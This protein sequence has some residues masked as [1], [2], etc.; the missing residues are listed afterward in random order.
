MTPGQNS[1]ITQKEKDGLTHYEDHAA[2][3]YGKISASI[4]SLVTYFLTSEF[5]FLATTIAMLAIMLA[6]VGNIK[7]HRNLIENGKGDVR[8][9]E[10]QYRYLSTAFMLIT[11]IW[12]FYCFILSD[13]SF[14]HLLCISTVLGNVL[15]LLSRNF[16]DDRTLTLQ[17]CAVGI[18]LIMGV[19]SYGD[20]RAMIL[21]GFFMPLFSSVHDISARLR[22]LFRNVEAQS[23]EKEAFG[24]QLNEAL[25]SMSHGLIMFDEEMRLR[26]INQTAR[27][28]LVISDDINCF[29]KRLS[30]ISRAIELQKPYV[31]R[32]QVLEEALRR[33]L[34][35]RA[36][37]K[38]F[39]MSEKQHIELSIKL[40]NRGGCVL[41]I[42]DV[43]QRI[44]YQD[45]INQLARFDDLTGLCNRNYFYQQ[46]ENMAA[47]LPGGQNAGIIFFDLD[48][49][50]RINDMLG[51]EAGDFILANVAER[52]RD[53]L[54]K[55]AI[56][57]RHGGD[58]FV[59]YVEGKYCPEGFEALAQQ[60]ISEL[61]RP[62]DYNKQNLRFGASI[63]V[64]VYPD[65]AITIDRLLKLA[66]LALYE[67]KKAGKNCYTFFSP[68]MEDTLQERL[69]MENDLTDA[70]RSNSLELH[71]QPIVSMATQKP[72][73]FEAL[74][75]WN[76]NNTDNVSPA[77]FIPL[78]EDLGLIREIGEWTLKE[79]CRQCTTWHPETSVAV[80]VSAVQF[81]VGSITEAVQAALIE[82]GLD[83]HRL[84]IEIT[85]SAVLNDMT[86]AVLVLERLSEIGVRISLDDFGTGYSSL[87]YL[88]KLPLD[89]L[90]I[91]KSFID[92]LVN[93]ERSKTLLKGITAM[94]RALDLRLVVEGIE[95][96]HQFDL[97]KD[98]YNVD[99][100]QGYF[101]SK[102]LPA[103]AA[104]QFAESYYSTDGD[105]LDSGTETNQMNDPR[106]A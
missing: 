88:H 54:P 57:G 37:N 24:I 46:S 97:L 41:V 86:H 27:Q 56:I 10:Y 17:L 100:M 4:A 65:D 77:I 26:V 59:I 9:W 16:L 105:A 62:L 106:V 33:R 40:R 43:S 60:L 50:K 42:E 12:S 64:A 22:S 29:G 18:P 84:E 35:N 2:F 52:M 70:V 73:V 98:H 76:R 34:Q 81:Q 20:F 5:T 94:G 49:F 58:E 47:S 95:N 36:H 3:F 25:E 75:R 104:K 1:T 28:I 21:C 92:D 38:I 79:A 15:N 8:V 45:R 51:H 61:T 71:F 80:N 13:N 32:V 102:A 82:T 53:F 68:E 87:S 63:G 55:Q 83:P 72:A 11:G 23:E 74:T 99:F 103:P 93:S 90:K 91:D 78:A 66:D 89:K 31:N 39:R 19:I 69:Q 85:E 96:Q 101:F 48:E 30:D 7:R 14:L 6:D 44:Q 67:S